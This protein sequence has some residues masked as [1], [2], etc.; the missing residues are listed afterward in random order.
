MAAPK[1][2]SLPTHLVDLAVRYLIEHAAILQEQKFDASSQMG[3]GLAAEIADIMAVQ[4]PQSVEQQIKALTDIMG[5]GPEDEA[6][7]NKV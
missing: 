1:T 5:V 6:V 3:R 2:V 7:G 4:I